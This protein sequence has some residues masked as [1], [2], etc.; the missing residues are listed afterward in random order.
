MELQTELIQKFATI[1]ANKT[2]RGES[3]TG[4]KAYCLYPTMI[5]P[6]HATEMSCFFVR[7][8]VDIP[9]YKPR[10]LEYDWANMVSRPRSTK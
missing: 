7:Q 9:A 2:E 5:L 1:C 8:R 10:F 6:G 3:H 4:D